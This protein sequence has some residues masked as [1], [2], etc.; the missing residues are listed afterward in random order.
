MLACRIVRFNES[1]Y[2]YIYIYDV[3]TNPPVFFL[4]FGIPNY[5]G[6]ICH[7]LFLLKRKASTD[8]THAFLHNLLLPGKVILPKM[9]FRKIQKSKNEANVI[10]GGQIMK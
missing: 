8:K 7:K 9:S 10:V 4:V 5:W 2:I 1:E 6:P 3:V